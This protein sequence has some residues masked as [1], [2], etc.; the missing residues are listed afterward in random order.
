MSV[1]NCAIFILVYDVWEPYLLFYLLKFIPGG[2][3]HIFVM[4]V[5]LRGQL[6]FPWYSGITLATRL[7]WNML[8]NSGA[9][10]LT[11]VFI[12]LIVSTFGALSLPFFWDYSHIPLYA[13]SEAKFSEMHLKINI[14][15]INKVKFVELEIESPVYNGAHCKAFL[16]GLVSFSL[17]PW[18]LTPSQCVLFCSLIIQLH[19]PVLS[20]ALNMTSWYLYCLKKATWCIWVD[21][22]WQQSKYFW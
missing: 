14:S 16:F 1:F 20:C 4:H 11:H 13:P 2:K 18:P 17:Q 22:F 10:L 21:D 3:A 7:A 15:R 8:L 6:L 19:W 5:E 12:F 9:I